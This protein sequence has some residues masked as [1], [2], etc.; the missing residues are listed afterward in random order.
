M[1]LVYLHFEQI[2]SL[3][4]SLHVPQGK[5]WSGEQCQISWAYFQKAVMTNEIV[6]SLIV[7]YTVLTIAISTQLSVP[8]SEQVWHKMI[9]RLHCQK[10][11]C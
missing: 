7:M 11:V 10:R 3:V 5:K 8:L 9:G 6:R 1:S 2:N 4:P